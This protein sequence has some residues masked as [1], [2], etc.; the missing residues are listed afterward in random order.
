MFNR[1]YI[2]KW[3]M[4]YCH[5]SFRGLDSRYD[6][7]RFLQD[8]SKPCGCQTPL[9]MVPK[10][11]NWDQKSTL[12]ETN[13]KSPLKIGHPKRKRSYSNHPF[14][15]AKM[16]V[17]GRVWIFWSSHHPNGVR[18]PTSFPT[19]FFFF[20]FFFFSSSFRPA[21]HFYGRYCGDQKM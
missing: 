15:G 1:K 21:R 13:I 3:W 4:F 14:S 12:P 16:L 6:S 10:E 18:V 19:S 20:F 7:E 17:S 9:R 8:S 2:F 5:I 11:S